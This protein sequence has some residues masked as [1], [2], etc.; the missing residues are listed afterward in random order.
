MLS[1]M[2]SENQY[3]KKFMPSAMTSMTVMP[4]CPAKM[5]PRAT[6]SAMRSAINIVVLSEFIGFRLP[7]FNSLSF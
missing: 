5:P 7:F 2:R 6:I 1:T 3:E 4:V